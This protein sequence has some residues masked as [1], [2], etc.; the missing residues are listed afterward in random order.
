MEKV[1]VKPTWQLAW[2]LWWRLFLI[3][4]G[5]IAV[6]VGISFAVAGAAL[7]AWLRAMPTMPY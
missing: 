4:L 6:I 1:V 3:Q 2:G 7:W 5:I